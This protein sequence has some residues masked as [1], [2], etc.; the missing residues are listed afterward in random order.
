M[1]DDFLGD[2]RKA[3][4]DQFFARENERLLRSLRKKEESSSQKQALSDAS[5]ITDDAVLD[6]LVELDLHADTLA[7]LSLVPLVAV[8]WASGRVERTEREAVLSAAGEH[9]LSADDDS[10]QLL[11]TWLRDRPAVDLVEAW[12]DYV[13]GL[14][15]HLDT[16]ARAA[17]R[18]DL[19]GRARTVAEAAGGILGFGSVSAEE[20]DVLQDLERAFA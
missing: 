12:K 18:D 8:A 16:A 14:C 7:A 3:L 5:G 13:R 11:T 19:I 1:S 6:R 4:E 20:R 2:R 15:E 10:Y 17:L 9:G